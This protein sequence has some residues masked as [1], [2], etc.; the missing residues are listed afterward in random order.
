M[1][2]IL[3]QTYQQLMIKMSESENVKLWLQLEPA[4]GN[5]T[6]IINKPFVKDL[7]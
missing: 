3:L 7:K 2:N 1:P 4:Y 6:K 5:Y